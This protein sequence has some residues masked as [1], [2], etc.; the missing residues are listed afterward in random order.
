MIF[1]KVPFES[2]PISRV[3]FLLFDRKKKGAP[4]IMM[5]RRRQESNPRTARRSAKRNADGAPPHH[6]SLFITSLLGH[7]H[8]FV[9]ALAGFLFTPKSPAPFGGARMS[10]GV[11]DFVCRAV[12]RV[13]VLH[14]RGLKDQLDERVLQGMRKA[15]HLP[16]TGAAFMPVHLRHIEAGGLE[17]TSTTIEFSVHRNTAS[18]ASSTNTPPADSA[19]KSQD[20]HARVTTLYD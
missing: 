1:C 11:L 2:K 10:P 3:T 8:R 20:F 17:R 7:P 16:W 4:N 18:P 15:G 13:L 5:M 19:V 6:G 9:Y 12:N 14:E